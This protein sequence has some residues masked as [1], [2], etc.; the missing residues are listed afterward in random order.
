VVNVGGH[1]FIT[2]PEDIFFPIRR[3]LMARAELKCPPD[4][5]LDMDEGLVHALLHAGNYKHGARS[6]GKILQ[7]FTV[8]RHGRL[9]RSLLM[10]VS[11]LNMHTNAA[12]FIELCTNAPQPFSPKAPL[13]IKQ[14]EVIAPAIHETF[15]K[16]GR[17]E[18]WL[19][20]KL[21][22]NFDLLDIFY[23][24]SNYEAAARMLKCLGLVG[25]QLADG[26]APTAEENAIRHYLEYYLEALAEAEHEGWMEWHISK[27]WRYADKRNDNERFHNCL[28]PYYQ[29]KQEERDKDRNSIRHFPDFAREAGMQIVFADRS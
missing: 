13:T 3:A 28:K 16:L 24:E 25:L 15:R 14:V 10:P 7:P 2:D 21:D 19:K 6:L 26:E 27:G 1:E 22:K 9:H 5:K 17:K 23:R 8:V 12:E 20:P 4:Y 18:G 11:Q 29:L